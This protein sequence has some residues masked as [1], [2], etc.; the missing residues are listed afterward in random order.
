MWLL[1]PTWDSSIAYAISATFDHLPPVSGWREFC[2]S[3]WGDSALS[4]VDTADRQVSGVTCQAAI[5]SSPFTFK[6]T[7][8]GKPGFENGNGKFSLL[9]R[10][11]GRN[12]PLVHGL[13]L[14]QH[15]FWSIRHIIG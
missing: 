12:P 3:A 7:L 5:A 4:I 6:E 11:T 15:N 14:G 10:D 9:A 13:D 2:S 1:G 8:N